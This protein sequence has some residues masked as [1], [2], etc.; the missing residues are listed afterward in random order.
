LAV[1]HVRASIAA[2]EQDSANQL[3]DDNRTMMDDRE[4]WLQQR[5]Y[6]IWEA[7][8]R[9]G[10][11][12]RDHWEQA[13]RELATSRAA[14][15]HGVVSDAAPSAAPVKKPRKRTATKPSGSAARTSKKQTEASPMDQ[16]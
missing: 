1:K 2:R 16:V 6:A 9:P 15:V 3:E 4:Q 12:D 10:G 5:A 8:G 11:R 13:E 14:K 7:E